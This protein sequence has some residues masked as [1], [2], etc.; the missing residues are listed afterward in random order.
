MN[1]FVSILAEHAPLLGFMLAI[2]LGWSGFLLWAIKG[3]TAFVVS[4]E[5]TRMD[6]RFETLEAQNIERKDGIHEAK[7]ALLELQKDLPLEYVRRE[8]WIRFS[9]ILEMKLDAVHRRIDDLA[10]EVRDGRT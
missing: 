2:I 4:R 9:S 7:V 10:R 5:I 3:I 1:G 8:D 6:E